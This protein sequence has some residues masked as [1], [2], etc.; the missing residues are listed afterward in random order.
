MALSAY[1]IYL[2]IVHFSNELESARHLSLKHA[3]WVV[4]STSSFHLFKIGGAV[5][6]DGQLRSGSIVQKLEWVVEVARLGQGFDLYQGGV[7]DRI[8]FLV[9]RWQVPPN[10]DCEP[11]KT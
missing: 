5:A 6:P 4:R 8:S 1:S 9:I 11:W 10:V 3:L 7:E 2:G